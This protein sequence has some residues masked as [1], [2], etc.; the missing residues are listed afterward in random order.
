MWAAPRTLISR[1]PF[2]AVNWLTGE[3]ELEGVNK[4]VERQMSFGVAQKE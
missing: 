1:R 3:T 2:Q 4:I